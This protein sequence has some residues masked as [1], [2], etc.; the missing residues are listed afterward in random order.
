MKLKHLLETVDEELNVT[1][2]GELSITD[3]TPNSI[4]P[5]EKVP[6]KFSKRDKR[7]NKFKIF[8]GFN[9]KQNLKGTSDTK[10]LIRVTVKAMNGK[11]AEIVNNLIDNM[12]HR[13][14]KTQEAQKLD[15]VVVPGSNS[16]INKLIAKKLKK[17]NPELEIVSDVLVKAAWKD[18]K[19]NPHFIGRED[20]KGYTQAGKAL[21]S[22]QKLHPDEPFQIKKAGSMSRRRYFSNFYKIP[23]DKVSEVIDT[24]HDK[25]ICVIDDTFEE[26]VTFIDI[27]RVL[28]DY[29]PK[30]IVGLI[31]LAGT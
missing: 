12:I 27:L 15:V 30:S 10:T 25:N 26:G 16:P 14:M 18:V 11:N 23:E 19:I 1:D 29:E 21:Q 31:L 5:T 7:G 24:I 9:F 2:D 17:L 6:V 4:L 3:D 22:K 13:F 8:T 28:G 20:P